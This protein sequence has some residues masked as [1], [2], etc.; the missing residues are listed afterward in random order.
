MDALP[1]AAVGLPAPAQR[2]QDALAGCRLTARAS[3]LS[4][5][6]CTAQQAADALGVGVGQIAKSIVVGAAACGRAVRAI[7]AGDRR[8]DQ[9]RIAAPVAEAI[10]Q[11][12]PDSVCSHAG[13][14]IG[15]VAPPSR[16][17]PMI[18]CVDAAVRRHAIAWAASDAPHHVFPI[19]PADLA[20]LAAGNERQ[21]G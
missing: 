14:A 2:V 9:A 15:G 8:V 19:A 12:A 17:Q 11:A 4:V 20:R 18:K 21:I 5:A 10:E 13:V 7:A 1:S 6:I 16:A 3:V